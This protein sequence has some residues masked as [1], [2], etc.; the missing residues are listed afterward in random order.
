MAEWNKGKVL[1]SAINGGQEFTKK[2]NLAV[3][4]L[5]AIVNNSFYASE[6]S[7]RAESLAESAVKGNGTLVTIG[8]Q[9]QG[10]WS[11]D[12]VEAERQK[13]KNLFNT[14]AVLFHISTQLGTVGSQLIQ[15]ESPRRLS[16]SND[17]L[18]KVK[19]NTQY[20]YLNN[21]NYQYAL[22]QVTSEK[23]SLG[24]SGWLN[25]TVYTFIT[26][27][28]TE[29]LSFNFRKLD[30]SDI[31]ESEFNSFLN[32]QI[33][34]CEGEDSSYQSYN[35]AIVHE[36]DLEPDLLYDKETKNV[37]GGLSYTDGLNGVSEYPLDSN[38][39]KK[40]KIYAYLTGVALICEI[41]LTEKYGNGYKGGL[42]SLS[43]DKSDIVML[44][45]SVGANKDY[46][47]FNLGFWS[48]NGVTL[49]NDDPSWF[50][51]R[52]EGVK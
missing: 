6:K 26:S 14:N 3:N 38:G 45:Y 8:G 9:I 20:T 36:K 17:Q 16:I 48:S 44:N 34:I 19:P 23:T 13:S 43:N 47:A 29:Y 21:P 37:L 24:D 11:A 2:D 49:R 10:E 4:E 40:L 12:F 25:D 41:D 42:A 1:P 32:S 5:N 39:Y 50:I 31:T 15:T 33:M 28:T 46:V 27:S 7:E 35:G 52:I 51:Y 22:G 30:N 18:F